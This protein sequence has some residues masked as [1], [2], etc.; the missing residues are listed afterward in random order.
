MSGLVFVSRS[1]VILGEY[2]SFI[3]CIIESS[4]E[5]APLTNLIGPFTKINPTP[6]I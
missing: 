5:Y 2:I 3:G 1:D 6:Y 4:L